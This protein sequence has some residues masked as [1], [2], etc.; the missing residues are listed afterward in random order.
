MQFSKV[1]LFSLNSCLY[2]TNAFVPNFFK[3]HRQH[4]VK[5][6]PVIGRQTVVSLASSFESDFGSAMPEKPKQTTSEKLE[7]SATSF[8]VTLDGRL[9]DGVEAPPELTALRE[10]RDNGAE[11]SE[12]VKLI[13]ELMIEQGMLY[14]EDAETGKLS[15]TEFDI[16]KNLDVPEVKAEFEYL[17][18]YG[19]GLIR[20]NMIDVEVAKTIVK[21][22]LID[23]TG[24]TPEVFDKWLGF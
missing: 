18:K 2:L 24:L 7:E 4:V 21:D 8:I 16:K 13:Y 15:P 20:Q 10:A 23:R 6:Q 12:M 11:D 1:F 5:N 19:M 22:R 9:A 3:T 17:Y 14:D